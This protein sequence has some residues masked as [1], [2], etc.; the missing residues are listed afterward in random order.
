MD[1]K[2]LAS[3]VSLGS[4]W[5]LQ[6][7]PYNIHLWL[8]TKIPKKKNVIRKTLQLYEVTFKRK[9]GGCVN[10]YGMS[11]GKVVLWPHLNSSN[12]TVNLNL[13]VLRRHS[14]AR[15][16]ARG[17]SVPFMSVWRN[18]WDLQQPSLT[19]YLNVAVSDPFSLWGHR[20]VLLIVLYCPCPPS[21]T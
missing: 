16:P 20:T 3:A 8:L 9:Q 11:R 21:A 2:R 13:T 18:R 12:V 10:C 17:T 6:H 15:G 5:C 7:W 14:A 1:T 4:I 19:P